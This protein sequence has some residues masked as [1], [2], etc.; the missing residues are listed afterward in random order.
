MHSTH[1]MTPFKVMYG[2][3]PDFI[4][5]VG[6]PTKFPSFNNRLH[7]LHKACKEVEAAL[8][9]EKQRMKETFKASKPSLRPFTPG[10]KVWLASKD[11]PL[12][13]KSRKL[14]PRQLGPY[15]VLKCTN[16]LTYRLHLS[17]SMHQHPIF[18]IDHLSPWSGNNING[19]NPPLPSPDE[20]DNQLEY[21]VESILDSRKY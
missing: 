17:P 11:I 5:P 21:K 13:S 18:H 15:K 4:I 1:Q 10:D 16:E 2:Y 19:A 12:V 6:S 3:Q 8:R 14:S 9:I 7:Q 20:I